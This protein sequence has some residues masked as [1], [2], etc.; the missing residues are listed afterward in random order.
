VRYARSDTRQVQATATVPL[1]EQQKTYPKE[2]LVP[3]RSLAIASLLLMPTV[4][5]LAT[6]MVLTWN[7][8]WA[9]APS[10]TPLQAESH[11]EQRE[12][13]STGKTATDGVIRYPSGPAHIT[14]I[15]ITLL[16]GQETGWHQHPVPIFGYILEGELTVDYGPHGP[17]T[18]RKGDGFIEAIGEVHEGRNASQQPVKILAVVIGQDGL[19]GSIPAS[20]PPH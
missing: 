11:L 19:P 14:A 10:P 20:P 1:Q 5:G 4:V 9:D 7:F 8:A 12:I 13:L 2:A 6:T 18:Y 17:R 3:E 16:P 15:E